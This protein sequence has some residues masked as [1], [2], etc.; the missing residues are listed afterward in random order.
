MSC[1]PLDETGPDDLEL[2]GRPAGLAPPEELARLHPDTPF[3]IGYS[4]I[5]DDWRKHN[6]KKAATS[7]WSAGKGVANQHRRNDRNAARHNAVIVHRYTASCGAAPPAS[8][9]LSRPSS[10]ST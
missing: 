6:K 4:R 5:S 3:L 2:R 7:A 9:A 10:P 8:P 1:A